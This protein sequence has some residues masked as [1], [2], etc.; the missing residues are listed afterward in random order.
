MTVTRRGFLGFACAAAVGIGTAPPAAAA[1]A[2]DL[3][4]RWLPH[5]SGADRQVD[6]AAWDALLAR[7]ARSDGDGIV[8]VAYA[9]VTAEDRGALRRYLDDLASEAVSQLD[10]PEQFAYW[11]NLY[12]ALTV[13]TVLAHY[14]VDSIRDIDISPGLFS[15]GP[16]GAKLIEV[17]ATALSLDDIEHRILRPIWNRDP[18]IH[19]AVNCAALGCPNLQPRAF[20]AATARATLDAAARAFVNH[21]RGAA[22][23][24][25]GLVVSSIYRWFREDFG[26]SEAGVIAHL[27]DYAEP[28]LAGRLAG[29]TGIFDH[30]YDWTLNAPISA[31][32]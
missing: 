4:P 8:R 15:S 32:G 19:Y 3:W 23:S 11:V 10:R 30:R 28:E 6:H 31:T 2:S 16:W 1:P 7:Y 24:N 20:R 29:V 26:D 21:P 5:V 9:A 14:P 27:R 12:N 13:E 22:F 17:E 18:L 25:G